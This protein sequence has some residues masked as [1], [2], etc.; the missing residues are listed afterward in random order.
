[1]VH[2]NVPSKKADPKQ[3]STSDLATRWMDR[4]AEDTEELVSEAIGHIRDVQLELVVGASKRIPLPHLALETAREKGLESGAEVAILLQSVSAGTDPAIADIY[5]M[6]TMLVKESGSAELLLSTMVDG[7][8]KE[9]ESNRC[10][11]GWPFP[12]PL[13]TA[14]GL[15]PSAFPH[16]PVP[17]ASPI[18]QS[19][20]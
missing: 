14:I 2:Y 4:L 12:S 1:M 5:D 15:P 20:R 8:Q 6:M 18:R 10:W 17:S 9:D 11:P 13:S 16:P 7:K 3:L 19:H